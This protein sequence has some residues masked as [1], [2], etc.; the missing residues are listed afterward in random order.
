MRD[1][2][3]RIGG[4]VGVALLAALPRSACGQ[5]AA[6]SLPLAQGRIPWLDAGIVVA[7]IGAALFVVCR[8]SQRV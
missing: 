7:L 5:S 2:A 3:C 8:S 4:L 6:L 1:R